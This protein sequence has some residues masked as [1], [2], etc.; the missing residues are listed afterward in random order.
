MLGGCPI[1][2]RKSLVQ[3]S[4]AA[5][6]T[7]FARVRVAHH[8]HGQIGG[9][10]REHQGCFTRGLAG[11]ALVVEC[12]GKPFMN[13]RLLRGAGCPPRF[14]QESLPFRSEP[15]PG[16]HIKTCQGEAWWQES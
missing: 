9:I 11:T 1:A 7:L 3:P 15:G 5:R 4:L 8:A 2:T 16:I 10:V 6:T 14:A 13:G 12:E